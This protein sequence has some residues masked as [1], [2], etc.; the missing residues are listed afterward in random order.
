MK[1]LAS[2]LKGKTATKKAKQSNEMEVETKEQT[3]EEI[4][5]AA[6]NKLIWQYKDAFKDF[7]PKDLKIMLEENGLSE[8][9][10]LQRIA[11][12]IDR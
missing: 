10:G 12:V 4:A 9:G 3:P 11:S 2:E 7:T 6:E 5:M 8:K 1:R